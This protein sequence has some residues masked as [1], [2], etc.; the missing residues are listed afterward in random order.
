MEK[1]LHLKDDGTYQQSVDYRYNIRGWLTHIN[2]SALTDDSG[3]TND[4]GNDYFGFE[5]RYN[6]PTTNG[7]A[8]Q[9][10]GNI[11]EVLWSN[12][13]SGRQS[14]A[15]SYDPLNRL[16]QAKYFDTNNPL[17]NN[18]FNEQITGYDRNGNILGTTRQGKTGEVA[19]SNTYGAM[20]NLGYS[21]QG[22]KLFRVDDSANSTS[23]EDGF[24]ELNTSSD[25]YEYDDNGNLTKDKNKGISSMTYNY[26]NLVDQVVSDNG[27]TISYTYDHNG[28][29]LKQEYAGNNGNPQKAIDFVG[30][31]VY[32]NNSLSL[33]NH[34]EGQIKM[35]SD[36]PEYQYA[37]KDNVKNTRVLFTSRDQTDSNLATFEDESE[38]NQFI[39]FEGIRRI[40]SSLFDHTHI[41]NGSGG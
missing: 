5:L 12:L 2:N 8:A 9:F 27:A 15:Y 35:N 39:N 16:T 32:E 30:S 41:V 18:R 26:M 25:D 40:N 31:F 38:Q 4:D 3:V 21:Y 22:N 17:N 37:L 28:I 36:G 11:S 29:R 6:T 34:D 23:E 13:V 1:N 19:F 10:N 14:Y 24:K 33:I 7:G 20:D